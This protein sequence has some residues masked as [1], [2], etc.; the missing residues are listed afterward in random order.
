MKYAAVIVVNYLN[1]WYTLSLDERITIE[2]EH[3]FP[4]VGA[5]VKRGGEITPVRAI[6]YGREAESF[7]ILGFDEMDNYLDLV[8]ELRSSHLLTSGLAAIDFE[9]VG[10]KEAYFAERDKDRSPGGAA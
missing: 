8:R 5:F 9:T 1:P 7:F 6:K 10:L 3:V 2:H 4:A